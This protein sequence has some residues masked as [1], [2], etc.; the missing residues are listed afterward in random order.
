VAGRGEH[1]QE[2]FL[3]GQSLLAETG[4]PE[5]DGAQMNALK[6]LSNGA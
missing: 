6:G 1:L 3:K 2:R 4:V 5:Y